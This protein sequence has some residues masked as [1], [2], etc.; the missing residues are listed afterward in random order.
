MSTD[1]PFNPGAVAIINDDDDEP[2]VIVLDADRGTAGDVHIEKLGQTVAE[3][4][5]DIDPDEPVVQVAFVG[6]L[7]K[8]APGWRDHQSTLA[9]WIDAYTDQWGVTITRYDYPISRLTPDSL[10]AKAR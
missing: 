8:N 1:R 5:D 7:D 6:D 4:N 10:P 3:A 9:D 2:H